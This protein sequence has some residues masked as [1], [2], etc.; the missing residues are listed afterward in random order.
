MS[1]PSTATNW[2]CEPTCSRT[3][4]ITRGDEEYFKI[5]IDDLI[6]LPH[7]IPA[8]KWKRRNFVYTTGEHLLSAE[9]INDL[10]MKEQDE[11]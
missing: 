4:P 9:S 8:G 5:Q 6:R 7:P 11:R 10:P 2:H 1:R 3:K